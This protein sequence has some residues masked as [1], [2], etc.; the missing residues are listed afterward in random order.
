MKIRGYRVSLD[1]LQAL[2]AG[3]P[4]VEEVIVKVSEDATGEKRL[5]AIIQ[6]T[7]GGRT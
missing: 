7:G 3:I 4:G 1:E 2:I 6:S 5:S